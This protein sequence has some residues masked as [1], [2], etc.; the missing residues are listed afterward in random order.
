MVAEEGLWQTMVI[1]E[2][3][4]DPYFTL[5]YSGVAEDPTVVVEEEF[6]S[7]ILKQRLKLMVRMY[8][9]KGLSSDLNHR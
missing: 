2:I 5:E 1:L 8:K 4:M 7:L 9:S 6:W 3:P